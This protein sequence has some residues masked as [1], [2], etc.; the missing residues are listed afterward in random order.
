M[1]LGYTPEARE[2]LERI[3]ANAAR[4]RTPA[5][6]HT[7]IGTIQMTIKRLVAFPLLG[8]ESGVVDTRT[9]VVP[10]LPYRIVYRVRG[11]DLIIV[12]VLY[13]SEQWPPEDSL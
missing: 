12:R 4:A 13:Q 3:H 7:T 8:R 1:N 2:D 10:R 5:H 9:L 11:N 6:A